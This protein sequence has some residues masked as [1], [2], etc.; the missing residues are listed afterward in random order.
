MHNKPLQ[1]QV[2]KYE[3]T[4]EHAASISLL[5]QWPSIHPSAKESCCLIKVKTKIYPEY[6]EDIP[7]CVYI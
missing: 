2:K 4:P 5:L 6:G 7:W 3:I 1:D